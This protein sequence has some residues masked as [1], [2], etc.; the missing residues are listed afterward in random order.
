M[1]INKL[2]SSLLLLSLSLCL[3]KAEVTVNPESVVSLLKRVANIDSEKFTVILDT[4]MTDKETFIIDRDGDKPLVKASTMSALTT[5]INWYLNHYAHVNIS[6][7]NLT[8]DL[9]NTQLPLPT[10]AESHTA[11]VDLRYYLNYCTFSY[12]M[13]T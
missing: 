1:N 2:F 11:N 6:W 7:N 12:S 5:G 8:T 4:E 13:S 9:S 3:A 10:S